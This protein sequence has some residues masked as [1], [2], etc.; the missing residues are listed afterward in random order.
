MKIE[1]SFASVPTSC[2]SQRGSIGPSLAA[3]WA[4]SSWA[5]TSAA[6]FARLASSRS[7]NRCRSAAVSRSAAAARRAVMA[8]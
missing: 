1:L 8:A 3:F 6:F 4:R 5:F 2:E 7:A